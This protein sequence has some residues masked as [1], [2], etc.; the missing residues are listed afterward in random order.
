MAGSILYPYQQKYLNDTSRF[1]AGMFSRQTGKTFTTTLEAVLD[2]LKAESEGRVAKWT[3]LS[4]SEPRAKDALDDGVKLHLKAFKT[5]FEYL[6]HTLD[7][8]EKSYE[9]CLP[10]GSRIRAIAS[11]PSTARGMSENLILDEFAHH[12]DSRAVWGALFPV[13]SKPNLKVRVISTPNGL[14]NK[15][16]EVMTSTEMGK[17]FSRHVV[18]IYKAVAD[19]LPRDIEELK[20]GLNDAELWAQEFECKFVDGATA[21]LPYALIDACE[22][23]GAGVPEFYTGKDCYTGVDFGRRRDLT[24]IYT[25]EKLENILWLRELQD[26]EKKPWREQKEKIK[27]TFE[28]YKI[29]RAAMDE[30]GMGSEPV[31][32]SQDNFGKHRVEGVW[33]TAQNKYDMA[34]LLKNRMEDRSIRLPRNM[35]LRDDLHSVKKTIGNSGT[36]RIVAPR[37]NGSHADRFWALALACLAADIGEPPDLSALQ[38]T[39]S[40]PMGDTWGRVEG[41]NRYAGY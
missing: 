9:V 22:D 2:C 25:C 36:P 32:W 1:K 39:G 12:A 20:T 28:S 3:I 7:S 40:A 13:I 34:V 37:E 23:D 15:F 27:Q 17:L 33:F 19:G 30:T 14:G 29:R 38:S 26:L 10:G 41:R 24:T 5:A 8:D 16:Y 21:F 18:D 6:E 35:K 4:V 31:E 11:K